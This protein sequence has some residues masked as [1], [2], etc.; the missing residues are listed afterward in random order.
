MVGRHKING[1][2]K[3]IVVEE[4]LIPAIMARR[5]ESVSKKIRR[6]LEENAQIEE[7]KAELYAKNFFGS[8][9]RDEA[10][11]LHNRMVF[12]LTSGFGFPYPPWIENDHRVIGASFCLTIPHGAQGNAVGFDLVYS[13]KCLKCPDGNCEYYAKDLVYMCNRAKQSKTNNEFNQSID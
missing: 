7:L 6:I 2:A 12:A 5:G 8:R 1:P 3:Q 4:A 10:N 13:N 11:E 9:A